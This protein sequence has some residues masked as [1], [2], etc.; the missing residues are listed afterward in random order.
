MSRKLPL[1]TLRRAAAPGPTYLSELPEPFNV[2]GV[3]VESDPLC[4]YDQWV[5]LGRPLVA[6]RYAL[7]S[8]GEL[9]GCSYCSTYMAPWRDVAI[10]CITPNNCVG[11]DLGLVTEAGDAWFPARITAVDD[12]TAARE[13]VTR[14]SGSDQPMYYWDH[15]LTVERAARYLDPDG[16]SVREPQL[17]VGQVDK[18]PRQVIGKPG[19]PDIAR[20]ADDGGIVAEGDGEGD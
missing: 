2:K 14:R 6:V 3:L 19:D 11:I 12:P 8:S 1:S 20:L 4:T 15:L 16:R 13:Y 10:L 17:Q 5:E 7:G 9:Y 18:S